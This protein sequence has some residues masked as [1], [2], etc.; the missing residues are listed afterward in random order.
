MIFPENILNKITLMANSPYISCKDYLVSGETFELFRH[1]EYEILETKPIPV[2]LPSYYSSEEYISHTDSKKTIIEKIYQQVKEYMLKKK[3]GWIKKYKK[4]GRILD[5]GAGTGDFLNTARKNGF[6]ALGIEPNK[7]ARF[8]AQSKGISLVRDY[9]Q[10]EINKFD[11]ISL[12]HVLEHLKDPVAEI[13]ILYNLLAEDG[14]LIIAVPNFKSFDAIHYEEFWAAYDVPRHL[15]HFSQEGMKAIFLKGGFSLIETKPLLFD[16]YY[17]SL[18]SEKNRTGSANFLR[19]FKTG[20][21][22]NLKA[23]SSTEYSSLT[24]FFKKT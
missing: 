12:W 15:F 5:V 1:P 10:L 7:M 22:S 9:E 21:R 16:S 2:N 4:S 11:V 8:K 17:V 20:L 19:A 14:I 3:L 24:Y 23:K 13:N 6:S 18:L